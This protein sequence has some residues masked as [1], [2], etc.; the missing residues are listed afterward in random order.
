MWLG[1]KEYIKDLL[2]KSLFLLI[3][4]WAITLLKR[5]IALIDFVLTEWKLKGKLLCWILLKERFNKKRD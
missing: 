3:Y 2:Q 5:N 1:G 4:P